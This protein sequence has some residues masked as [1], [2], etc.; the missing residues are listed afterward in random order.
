MAKNNE[1]NTGMNVP[2]MSGVGKGPAGNVP[3]APA[4]KKVET[5]AENQEKNK[6]PEEEVDKAEQYRKR[7]K[8]AGITPAK[9]REILDEVLHN[10]AYVRQIKLAA[11]FVVEL[12][13]RVYGD[14]VRV[15]RVIESEAPA[16]GMHVNDI[17]ARYNLA[18]SLHRYGN[19]TFTAR[20]PK[21]SEKD[22]AAFQERL[23]FVMGLPEPVIRRLLDELNRFDD[24][25]SFILSEGAIEDF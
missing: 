2:L 19:T 6:S 25:M 7:L 20:D 12:A 8:D 5:S 1:K 10:G 14:T 18:A 15:S 9:A 17:I 22:E 11:N 3:R 16:F 4:S 21:D 23:S 13:T 24:E